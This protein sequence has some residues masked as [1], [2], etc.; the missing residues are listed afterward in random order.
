MTVIKE[1][2]PMGGKHCITS[3]LNQVFRYYGFPISEEMLFGIGSGLAF[4]YINLKASPMIS[5][6]IKVFEFE[7]KIADRLNI[8]MKLKSTGNYEAAFFRTKELIAL[9]KPVLAYADMQYL[10]Y[11]NLPETSH[12]GGH[13]VVLFGFDDSDSKFYV[14]DRDNSDYP[15]PTPVGPISED[16]HLIDYSQLEK[17]RSS[18]HRPFPPNNRWIEFDFSKCKPVSKQIILQAIA[19]TC[20]SMLNPPAKLMGVSGINKFSKEVLKWAKFDEEK[21]KRAGSTNYFMI[22]ADGGTGG[23]IFR[24]MYGKFLLEAG[25][26][27]Y[28]SDLKIPGSKFIEAGRKWEEVAAMLKDLS[29]SG[30]VSILK[31]I[32]E[33]AYELYKA[34]T[35]ILTTLSKLAE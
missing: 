11:F 5:G 24:D 6:R 22:S 23:G 1:F 14:S 9:G 29:E 21:I 4:T 25:S 35:D 2:K 3:S 16:F 17:A 19:E 27:F 12:F 20:S 13:S 33:L 32:S 26:E 10:N 15:V 18:K 28:L 8:E 30:K 34:E 7:E 31:G